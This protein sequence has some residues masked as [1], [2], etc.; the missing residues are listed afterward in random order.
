[1]ILAMLD[2]VQDYIHTR[3]LQASFSDDDIAN[4]NTPCRILSMAHKDQ[5]VF[6]LFNN[7]G[8]IARTRFQIFNRHGYIL[9]HLLHLR[10]HLQVKAQL[11]QAL[12][13]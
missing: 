2:N 5:T 8:T 7:Y 10:H 12:D 11:I 9:Q 4:I 6:R 13:K 1:M 3:L